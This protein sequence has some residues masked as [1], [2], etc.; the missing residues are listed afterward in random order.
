LQNRRAWLARGEWPWLAG[1]T[2]S[3]G[4]IAPILLMSGLRI[5]TASSA[6]L[7]LNLEGVFT[8]CFAWFLFHEQAGR[9]VMLGMLLIV[10]AGVLLSWSPAASANVGASGMSAGSLLIVGACA[11][12]AIDNNLT[13]K[14][15]A[16]DPVQIAAIKGLAAGVVNLGLAVSLSMP[17]PAWPSATAAAAIGFASYGVSLVLFVLALRHL[18]TA[19]TA[20]YFSAA[21][22][23]GVVLSILILHDAPTPLFWIAM[24][25]MAA[26][27]WLHLTE[28]HV[29]RH[30]HL[31]MQ[32]V[33]SHEHDAHH[34]HTHDFQWDGS[35]PHTH[36]H[37]HQ[38]QDHEHPH[39]PDIHHRHRHRRHL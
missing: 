32:H 35:A 31:P 12:W 5:S 34:Q 22:F 1:A 10:I 18:G 6:S 9:R 30:R 8:A 2:L 13:R 36:L 7:L 11:G 20:A 37:A 27:L 15:S 21:P 33:H 3:G 19:R 4:I 28:H 29:H 14:V 17:F 24:A 39:V 16:A 26:G 25:L 38:E 23:A